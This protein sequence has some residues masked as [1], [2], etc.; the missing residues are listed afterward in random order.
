MSPAYDLVCSKL[1]IPNEEDSALTIQVK[2]NDIQ[3]KDFNA[4][5]DY[6]HIPQKVRY[7]KF[8][9]KKNMIHKI[10]LSSEIPRKS[11]NQ[12]VEIVEERYLRIGL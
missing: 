5:A 10:I 8:R 3:K 4:L 6:F 11:Q 1:V 12:F 2:K 7:E 9:Q